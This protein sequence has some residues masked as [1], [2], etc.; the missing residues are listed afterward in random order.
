VDERASWHDCV[1]GTVPLVPITGCVK[2]GDS[3][4]SSRFRLA[5]PVLFH[6]QMMLSAQA[7]FAPRPIGVTHAMAVDMIRCLTAMRELAAEED[8][9]P[10]ARALRLAQYAECAAGHYC[11]EVAF[12]PVA[13][14]LRSIAA[15]LEAERIDAAIVE[16]W[17]AVV[18][19]LAREHALR[20]W[21]GRP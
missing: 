14:A 7:S 3:R 13:M 9:A 17:L 2:S 6:G 4:R 5:W 16:T 8:L 15:R 1:C 20:P 21:M 10:A 18:D 11:P 12:D 19:R